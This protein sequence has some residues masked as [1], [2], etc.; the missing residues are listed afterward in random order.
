MCRKVLNGLYISM[1]RWWLTASIN[2][3]CACNWFV[4][5]NL[6]KLARSVLMFYSRSIS[7]YDIFWFKEDTDFRKRCVEFQMFA[8]NLTLNQAQWAQCGRC[9]P[10]TNVNTI[11]TKKIVYDRNSSIPIQNILFWIVHSDSFV[12]VFITEICLTGCAFARSKKSNYQQNVNW[13]LHR[14]ASTTEKAEG[15]WAKNHQLN[16]YEV[17]FIVVIPL[18]TL[19]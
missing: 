18:R 4:Q 7:D 10:K 17:C 9:P 11:A 1:I 15:R 6:Y 5:Y 14:S 8:F 19:S 2:S 12:L 3:L 13:W 16:T